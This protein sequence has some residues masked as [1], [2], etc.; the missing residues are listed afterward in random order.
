MHVDASDYG[1]GAV[2]L[3]ESEQKLIIQITVQTS[4]KF[5]A[6]SV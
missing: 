4:D 3:Q 1:A 6:T 2:L 5:N